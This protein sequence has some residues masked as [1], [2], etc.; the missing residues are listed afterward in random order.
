MDC[1]PSCKIDYQVTQLFSLRHQ[2]H[3]W[4][5]GIGMG[6]EVGNPF[7][8]SFINVLSLLILEMRIGIKELMGFWCNEK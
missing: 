2:R 5:S 7:H 4:Y 3:V 6:M 1:I 8:F